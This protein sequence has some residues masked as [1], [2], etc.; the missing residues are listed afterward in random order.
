MPRKAAEQSPRNR[1]KT[2]PRLQEDSGFAGAANGLARSDRAKVA[3]LT[4]FPRVPITLYILPYRYLYR[5]D[6]YC[7]LLTPQAIMH[8]MHAMH[9]MHNIFAQS[10]PYR[11]YAHPCPPM[12][13]LILSSSHPLSLR[14]LSFSESTAEAD[15]SS[16]YSSQSSTP[17]SPE[18]L[19]AKSPRTPSH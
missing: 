17:T 12:P 1:D 11:E 7:I 3:L 4:D 18:M 16:K 5:T 8:V 6:S 19:R 9:V 15:T 2:G 14:A 13:G 10:K